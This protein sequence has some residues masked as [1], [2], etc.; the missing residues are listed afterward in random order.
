MANNTRKTVDGQ[1]LEYLRTYEILFFSKRA[2][3]GDHLGTSGDQLETS[4]RPF[5]DHLETIWRPVVDQLET[6]WRPVG[7]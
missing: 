4:W 6:S 3:S 5:G 2:R 7:D 1:Y